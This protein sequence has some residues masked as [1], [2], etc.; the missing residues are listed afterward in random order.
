[1]DSASKWEA[2]RPQ[3]EGVFRALV[4]AVLRKDN[5]VCVIISDAMRYEI[6]DVC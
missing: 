2:F 4:P 3:A 6:G 5:K 1:V